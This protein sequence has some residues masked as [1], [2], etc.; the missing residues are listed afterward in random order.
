MSTQKTHSSSSHPI[1]DE[2]Y[3]VQYDYEYN[4]RACIRKGTRREIA[5]AY[6]STWE[7]APNETSYMSLGADYTDITPSVDNTECMNFKLIAHIDVKNCV[8]TMLEET[9]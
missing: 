6:V 2:V 1:D 5:Q 3:I 7:G 4:T 9:K 8:L